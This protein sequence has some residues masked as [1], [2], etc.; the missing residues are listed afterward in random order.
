MSN[1]Q[2]SG[3][4]DLSEYRKILLHDGVEVSHTGDTEPTLLKTYTLPAGTLGINGSLRYII[5]GF[6]HGGNGSTVISVEIDGEDVFNHS[7]PPDIEAQPFIIKGIIFNEQAVDV[8]T[9]IAQMAYN[10]DKIESQYYDSYA[11]NTGEENLDIEV[12]GGLDNADDSV[13]ISHFEIEVM[14]SD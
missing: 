13:H 5:E 12:Y 10:V 2:S 4:V 8:N 7:I 1:T 9:L 14:P 6:V 3:A 11:L